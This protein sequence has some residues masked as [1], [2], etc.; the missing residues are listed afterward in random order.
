MSVCVSAVFTDSSYDLL[1]SPEILSDCDP[2][3]P[4]S[5]TIYMPSCRW[6]I[7]HVADEISGSVHE[8][9]CFGNSDNRLFGHSECVF[10]L[11]THQELLIKSTG[12]QVEKGILDSAM[13]KSHIHDISIYIYIYIHN[14]KVLHFF[15]LSFR[16][17]WHHK[18]LCNAWF[19]CVSI[20][21]KHRNKQLLEI[22]LKIIHSLF[23]CRW[24]NTLA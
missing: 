12:W 4:L 15:C 16:D 5:W 9:F 6:L 3:S 11:Q 23:Y 7:H 24:Y 14:F 1:C 21:K 2:L 17:W 10:F 18:L 8:S 19:R 22:G 13:L 20:I